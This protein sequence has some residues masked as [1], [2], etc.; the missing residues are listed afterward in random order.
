VG[1]N[2]T[3]MEP[4][5]KRRRKR[6]GTMNATEK[7]SESADVPSKLALVISR[8]RPKTLDRSVSRDSAEPCLSNYSELEAML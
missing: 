1:I 6:F 2:A 4:S 8:T 3:D 5:A 7:A